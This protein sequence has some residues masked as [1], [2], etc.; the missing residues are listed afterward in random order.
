MFSDQRLA[1]TYFVRAEVRAARWEDW[2]RPRVES[3]IRTCHLL[4]LPDEVTL[5]HYIEA[6]RMSVDLDL[7]RGVQREDLWMLAQS[8][9]YDLTIASDDANALRVAKQLRISAITTLDPTRMDD[10]YRQDA[11]QLRRMPRS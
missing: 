4:P 9:S 10:L 11:R 2:L 7:D 8:R 1:V 5:L 6:K 3:L